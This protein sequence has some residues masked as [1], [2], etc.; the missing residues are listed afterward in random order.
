MKKVMTKLSSTIL[1]LTLI[2]LTLPANAE[3]PAW[4]FELTPLPVVCRHRCGHNGGK[5]ER[6]GGCWFRRSH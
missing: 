3:E 5:Q 1:F 2:A 4:K 6:E